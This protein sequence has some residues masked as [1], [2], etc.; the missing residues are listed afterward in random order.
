M[1][2]YH[3]IFSILLGIALWGG[4]SSAYARDGLDY[5]ADFL[6]TTRAGQATFTQIVTSPAPQNQIE[7][8]PQNTTQNPAV[9]TERSTGTFSFQRPGQLRFEYEKP[10]AQTIVADGQYIWLHDH[11]LEQITRRAQA[12]LLQSTP[13]AVLVTA[14]DIAALRQHFSLSAEPAQAADAPVAHWV[15]ATPKNLSNQTDSAS[16]ITRAR[17]G[18]EAQGQLVA[19]EMEDAFGQTSRLHFSQVRFVPSLPAPT[20]TFTPPPGVAVVQH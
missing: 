3:H 5:L 7:N 12:Q 18:F 14:S 13:A 17:I 6:K 10:F 19:L 8:Q 4:F 2:I 16:A 9:K 11:D 20:F 1:T 15:I